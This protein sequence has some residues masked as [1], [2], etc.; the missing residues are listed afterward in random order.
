MP[1]CVRN[2]YRE[3]TLSH[4]YV[5]NIGSTNMESYRSGHNG[6]ALKAVWAHAHVGSNPTLSATSMTVILSK[7][8]VILFMILWRKGGE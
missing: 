4:L 1:E 3:L 6:A 5:I 7:I 2:E 8:T